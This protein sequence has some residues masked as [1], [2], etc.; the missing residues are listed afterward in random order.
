MADANKWVG[1]CRVVDEMEYADS[2]GRIE[3]GRHASYEQAVAAAVEFSKL[4]EYAVRP[5]AY[6]RR[7]NDR[8]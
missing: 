5:S 1:F 6:M 8:H 3:C 7:P 2:D 4:H